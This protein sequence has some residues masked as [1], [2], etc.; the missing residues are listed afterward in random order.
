MPARQA[1]QLESNP[2]TAQQAS[3]PRRPLSIEVDPT[4]ITVARPAAQRRSMQA[5]SHVAKARAIIAESDQ[6]RRVSESTS[7]YAGDMAASLRQRTRVPAGPVEY[8]H[9]LR[10]MGPLAALVAP[11]AALSIG[12]VLLALGGN[13]VSGVSGFLLT[14]MAAPTMLLVGVPVTGGT[15]RY[16]LAAATSMVLWLGLG[17]WASARA[18]RNPVASWRD[19]WKEYAFLVVPVWIGAAIAFGVAYTVVL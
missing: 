5:P 8:R 11:L 1:R 12:G 4:P 3:G 14:A 17:A 10:R 9:Q 2:M 7:P 15:A 13:S 19:W 6:A 18:T 16:V